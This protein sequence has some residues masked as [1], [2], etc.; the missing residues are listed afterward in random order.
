MLDTLIVVWM[1]V[2]LLIMFLMSWAIVF[3]LRSA[4]RRNEFLTSLLA[5]GHAHGG[6]GKDAARAQ[7]A[8]VRELKKR[9]D[10]ASAGVLDVPGTLQTEHR[11]GLRFR[12]TTP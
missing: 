11:P 12:Q 10:K 8:A 9:A 1:L 7:V 5:V 3:G 6:N 4:L 2:T